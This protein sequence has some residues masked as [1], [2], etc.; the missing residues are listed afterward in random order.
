MLALPQ[1]SIVKGLQQDYVPRGLHRIIE[2]QQLRHADSVALIYDHGQEES[3]AAS[4]S[5]YRHMNESANR[6]ARLLVEEAQRCFLQPNNDGDFILAVCMQP[7]EALV[8]TLLAIWKAGGAYLPIDPSFPANR[9]HHILLEARPILVLRDDDIDAQRFQGTPTLSLTEL[10]AKSLQLSGSN[11]LSEEMLRGGN[12]HIAIVLYTSGSTGVPKGVRLPHENI[13]NRLQWQ[14]ATFPYTANEQVGVFKTALT[15]VDSVAEL[16]GPLMCGLSIVV[17]PKAV[18]KDPHRLVSLLEK[19]K[20]RRLVLVPTLLRSLLMYLNMETPDPGQKL[21]HNLQ[22]WVC[23]GE[24]LV[25]PLASSF[26]DYFDEGV[27]R[28]YNFYGSTEVMGDVTYFACESKKQLSMYDN[29]PIGVPVSNTVI[30][31]LDAD[32][33]PVKNGEIG[34]IFASGL[35]LAAGYVNG[36]DPERFLENPLA[37]EKKYARLYRTGDYGSL[38]NGNIMYEGRTDSQVKIRGHRVDLSEVEK[39]VA[40]LP[41]VEKAI[42][43]CYRAGH[44]DQAILAFVK[45]RDDSPVVTEMQLEGRLKDKLADYMTPQVIILEHVPLLVNGKVDRQALLKTYEMANNDQ[46]GS[47][48]VPDFDYSHVPEELKLTARDLFETVSTVIGRSRRATLSAHSNFYDLGGNSLNSIFTVTLL[49]EK[50]YKIGISDFIAA[51]NLGEIIEKMASNHDA[52]QLEE[53]TLNA[54]PHL[55]ME[56]VLLQE[57]HHQPVTLSYPV[58]TTKAI[59]SNG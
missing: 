25:V 47:A 21:L 42:V 51:K 28:L 3:S 38:K 30:Y 35:N 58:S 17:V 4:Q 56:A 45:L 36:R 9:V 24:P 2:E 50:G 11:L 15:F 23:S 53:E 57:A 46:G 12:E 49:R 13:L 39:I 32:Y 48:S 7:S 6:A 14:W 10:Y 19:Y 54:C 5:T 8:T 33:R 18:T 31:L 44:V 27:H 22:I 29:V 34:E 26:F 1:L 16:W 40:E 37:V 55:Q 52:V 20:I 59:W 41:L 43:L